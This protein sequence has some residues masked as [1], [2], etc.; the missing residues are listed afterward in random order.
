MNINAWE[1][2]EEYHKR[3]REENPEQYEAM[4][5]ALEEIEKQKKN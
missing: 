3:M 5:K 1:S 4:D 2:A